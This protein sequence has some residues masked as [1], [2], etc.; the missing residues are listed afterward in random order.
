[1][2][3]VTKK[4]RTPSEFASF[5]FEMSQLNPNGFRNPGRRGTSLLEK[6]SLETGLLD[7]E[8]LKPEMTHRRRLRLKR[9]ARYFAQIKADRAAGLESREIRERIWKAKKRQAA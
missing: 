1:M 2:P 4:S 7:E 5:A 9:R 8:D 3:I 6:V